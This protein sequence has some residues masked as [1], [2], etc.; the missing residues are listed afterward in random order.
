MFSLKIFNKID[1]RSSNFDETLKTILGILNSKLK[2]P[3]KVISDKNCIEVTFGSSEWPIDDGIV[4]ELV[5]KKTLFINN[6]DLKDRCKLDAYISEIRGFCDGATSIENVEYLP[7]HFRE[8][9]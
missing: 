7:L 5:I 3:T 1:N 9:T 8:Q 6:D 2:K 4:T